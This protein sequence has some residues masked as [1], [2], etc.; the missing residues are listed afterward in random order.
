MQSKNNNTA[1][2]VGLIVVIILTLVVMVWRIMAAIQPTTSSAPQVT[3]ATPTGNPTLQTASATDGSSVGPGQVREM[4]GLDSDPTPDDIARGVGIPPN[5]RNAFPVIKDP[6]LPPA[7][8]RSGSSGPV[9]PAGPGVGQVTP[10]Y[11]IPGGPGSFPGAGPV[12]PRMVT[13]TRNIKVEGVVTGPDGFAMITEGDLTY[14]KRVGDTLHGYRIMRLHENGVTARP[15]NGTVEDA[16]IWPIGEV[17][18]I[19]I[20]TR[21]PQVAPLTTAPLPSGPSAS[22][23]GGF[24]QGTPAP[25][26][27]TQTP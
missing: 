9:R 12:G 15:V 19:P 1:T 20:Q 17:S 22:P 26:V 21:A 8:A 25:R 3:T 14:F 27:P 16:T 4:T 7:I 10:G 5:P 2:V 24:Q 6:T 18:Q 13:V 23:L 11:G